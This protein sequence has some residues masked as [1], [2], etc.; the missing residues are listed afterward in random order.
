MIDCESVIFS[1][2]ADKFSDTYPDGSRY[3]EPVDSPA[4]FPC[5]TLVEIDN[6]TYQQSQDSNLIEHHANITYEVNVYS[7]K[8]SGAKQECKAIIAL[9]DEQ[10]QQMGF[11]RLF[12]NQV[13]NIDKKVYR[14]TAR[15]RGVIGTD[16]RIYRR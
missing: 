14:M 7:N 1:R 3:G 10:M 11:T 12:C 2:I 13:P 5:M 15:Y 9:I 6:S 4:R 8:I 16:Y